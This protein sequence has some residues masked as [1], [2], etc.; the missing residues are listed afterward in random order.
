[1]KAYTDEGL[2]D[3]YLA[4]RQALLDSVPTEST[5]SLKTFIGRNIVDISVFSTWPPE[6]YLKM[7]DIEKKQVFSQCEGLLAIDTGDR[8]CFACYFADEILSISIKFCE[9]FATKESNKRLYKHSIHD[10]RY[11][12]PRFLDFLGKTIAGFSMLRN[13]GAGN[14]PSLIHPNEHALGI[15][16]TDGT[17]LVFGGYVFPGFRVELGTEEDL[18]DRSKLLIQPLT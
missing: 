15:T 6:K 9:S 14:T 17:M 10:A 1:M 12:E 13:K 2:K 18:E 7:R 16:F 5:D 4:K 3:P 8:H 11:T